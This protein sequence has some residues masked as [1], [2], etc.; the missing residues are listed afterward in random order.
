MGVEGSNSLVASQ[1]ADCRQDSQQQSLSTPNM[2]RVASTAAAGTDPVQ[3]TL[4]VLRKEESNSPVASQA[5]RGRQDSQEKRLGGAASMTAAAATDAVQPTLVVKAVLR[6][7]ESNNSV[8]SQAAGGRQDSQAKSLSGAASMTAAAATL[9]PTLVVDATAHAAVSQAAFGRQGSQVQSLIAPHM[10]RVASMTEAAATD[11]V[12]LADSR[13]DLQ[14]NAV[15]SGQAEGTPTLV[16]AA[17]H[18]SISAARSEVPAANASASAMANIPP[19]LSLAEQLV[20][21]QCVSEPGEGPTLPGDPDMASGGSPA[22]SPMPKA[23]ARRLVGKQPPE[24]R[25]GCLRSGSAILRERIGH[26]LQP[27]ERGFLVRVHG[28]GWGSAGG[29]GGAGFLA[30]VTE[31]DALTFTVIRRPG[32]DTRAWE[33]THVLRRYCTVVARSA[34]QECNALKGWGS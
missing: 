25:A 17:A 20:L 19:I 4:V 22:R 27:R 9:Q 21:S 1:A 31:A 10:A 5:A 7:E 29:A 32:G 33:E 13:L 2:A 12:Q 14:A 18:A 30:T 23:K 16:D 28:D 15:S 26:I 24:S 11:P 8:A 3:P 34:S 6:T